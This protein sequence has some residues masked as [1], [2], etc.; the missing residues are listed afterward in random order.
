MSKNNFT[1]QDLIDKGFEQGQDGTWQRKR[2]VNMIAR[3]EKPLVEY[4]H[5]MSQIKSEVSKAK[6]I[7]FEIPDQYTPIDNGI[8]IRLNGLTPGLNGN[9]GLMREDW[10]GRK[11]IQ[12]EYVARLNN[13]K[14]PPIQGA[15]RLIYIRHTSSFMDWDNACASFKKIG[16]ALVKSGILKNDDPKTI[17]EFIP[18][19]IKCKR[20]DQHTEIII[21][22]K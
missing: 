15:V 21:L 17:V 1:E 12:A 14:I 16:D 20:K 4:N 3:M 13:L 6:I 2:S 19:Q 7:L 11:K 18:Q 10:R 5:V 8:K 9:K 22:P